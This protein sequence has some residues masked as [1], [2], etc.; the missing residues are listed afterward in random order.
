M[1]KIISTIIILGSTITYSMNN[2]PTNQHIVLPQQVVLNVIELQA[3]QNIVEFT[4]NQ[5]PKN[6]PAPDK[7]SQYS[8]MP[9][10]KKYS[11]GLKQPQGKR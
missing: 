5:K 3:G 10:Q 11:C 9:R 4:A 8:K 2:N 1:K 7:P 6:S